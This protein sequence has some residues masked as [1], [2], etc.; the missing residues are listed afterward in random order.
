MAEN[1]QSEVVGTINHMK[2]KGSLKILIFSLL[3]GFLLLLIGGLGIF[4]REEKMGTGQPDE[5][6]YASFYEYKE[7]LESEIRLICESVSG[8]D[9]VS[10]I[11]FFDGVG[12]SIYAKDTQIGTSE[13]TEYVIIGS[14]SSSHALYLGESLPKISGIGVICK[15]GG[16][17][18]IRNEITAL[19]A[20]TYGLSMTRIYV[21]EAG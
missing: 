21:A 7:A 9:A 3:V 16:R 11:T 17:E 15:T 13:R 19:L 5:N 4:D 10:V 1:K 18:D 2:K 20:A 14:G 12:E 8:V 6:K